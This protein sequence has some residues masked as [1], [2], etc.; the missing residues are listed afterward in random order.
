MKEEDKLYMNIHTGNV[1]PL[2]IWKADYRNDPFKEDRTFEEWGSCLVEVQLDE[3]GD[4]I[5]VE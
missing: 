2:C 4:W 1:D 3:N 5:E